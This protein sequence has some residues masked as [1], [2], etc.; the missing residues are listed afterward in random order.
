MIGE[1]HI[2]VRTLSPYVLGSSLLG[3]ANTF[4]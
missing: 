3:G 4:L 2:K 1:I